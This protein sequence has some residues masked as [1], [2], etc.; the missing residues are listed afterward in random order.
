MTSIFAFCSSK[1]AGS[2]RFMIIEKAENRYLRKRS[3][4]TDFR[5]ADKTKYVFDK[6]HDS[7]QLTFSQFLTSLLVE[8]KYLTIFDEFLLVNL[9]NIDARILRL[10]FGRR[11]F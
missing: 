3:A 6:K 2:A 1:S 5:K 8:K 4:R 11:S 10:I 7:S 9:M